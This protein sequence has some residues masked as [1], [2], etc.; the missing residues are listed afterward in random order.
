MF[1]I[2]SRRSKV[3]TGA[4]TQTVN[5]CTSANQDGVYDYIVRLRPPFTTEDELAAQG[6]AS[7]E[8]LL[9]YLQ[10]HHGADIEKAPGKGPSGIAGPA[11]PL[12]AWEDAARTAVEAAIDQLVLEFVEHPYLHRVEHSL[13][14]RLYQLMAAKPA[15]RGTLPF[16][17]WVT[18]PIHKEWPEWVVRPEKDTR[19][20]YDLAVL[21]PQ[22]VEGASLDDFL[23]G[24]LRPFIAIEI[25][26]DYKY[27]HLDQ[28]IRKLENSGIPDSYILHLVRQDVT[29]DF[30]GVERRLLG[31]GF[32]TAY[33]HHLGTRARFKLVG[34]DN[35]RE[36][37][38]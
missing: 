6:F 14:C 2:A 7:I 13:H 26:L 28:D 12:S 35:I 24:R 4:R 21:S 25:G 22:V 29:D 3:A 10:V 18:Q 8:S 5:I 36:G 31:C 30:P 32:R 37:A 1:T 38:L 19:G 20:G 27:D 15:L 9:D 34:D 23:Q 11:A 33:V 17:R 16:G